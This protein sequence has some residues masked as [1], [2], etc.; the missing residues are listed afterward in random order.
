MRGPLFRRFPQL[1]AQNCRKFGGKFVLAALPAQ[2]KGAKLFAGGRTSERLGRA[3]A[4]CIF[5]G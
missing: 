4:A 1:C 3:A 5:S 2:T